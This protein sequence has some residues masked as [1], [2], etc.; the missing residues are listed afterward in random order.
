MNRDDEAR[1]WS[2]R[3]DGVVVLLWLVV[4]WWLNRR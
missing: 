1:R 4:M 3:F 2:A